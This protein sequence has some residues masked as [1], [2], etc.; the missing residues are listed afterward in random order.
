MIP[1]YLM[2]L[3]KLKRHTY[4]VEL[5][6]FLMQYKNPKQQNLAFTYN[7]IP[8]TKT[9]KHKKTNLKF[10]MYKIFTFVSVSNFLFFESLDFFSFFRLGCFS[11][12]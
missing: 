7:P 9:F 3:N 1:L 5:Q 8:Y 4:S 2:L 12:G 11:G 10:P 6:N